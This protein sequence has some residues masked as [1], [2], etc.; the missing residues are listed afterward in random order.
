MSCNVHQGVFY[1]GFRRH[2]IKKEDAN[3]DLDLYGFSYPS[4]SEK[5]VTQ[6]YSFAWTGHVGAVVK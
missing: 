5:H 1:A 6:I 4:Y 3:Q 2:A